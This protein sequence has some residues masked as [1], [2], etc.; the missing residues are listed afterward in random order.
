VGRLALSMR[1]AAVRCVTFPGPWSSVAI[2]AAMNIAM[3]WRTGVHIRA[4]AQA[5]QPT[6][7]DLDGHR[8]GSGSANMMSI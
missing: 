2:L 4:V 5:D 7:T 8:P 3:T 1:A 6:G